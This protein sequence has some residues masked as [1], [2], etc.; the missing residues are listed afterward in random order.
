MYV[1]VC[2]C[3]CVSILGG[4]VVCCSLRVMMNV[5][6]SEVVK[7]GRDG[8]RK[9]KSKEKRRKEEERKDKKERRGKKGR[10]IN[11]VCADHRHR[12]ALFL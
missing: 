8:G 1:Y 4:R 10:E 3:V 2:V 6:R 5:P 9:K 12:L 11:T 7:K